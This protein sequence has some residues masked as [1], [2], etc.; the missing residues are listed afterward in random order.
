MLDRFN[1]D[2][3]ERQCPPVAE[4]CLHQAVVSYWAQN[5]QTVRIVLGPQWYP[6][7]WVV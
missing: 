6:E 4:L 2:A 7:E 5:V 3:N 1:R